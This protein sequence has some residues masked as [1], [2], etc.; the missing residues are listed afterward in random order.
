ME[1][2]TFWLFCCYFDVLRL[3]LLKFELVIWG[4]EGKVHHI[5]QEHPPQMYC[6][7]LYFVSLYEVAVA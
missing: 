1:E 6:Y 7:I 5:D 4:K 2:N 3:N